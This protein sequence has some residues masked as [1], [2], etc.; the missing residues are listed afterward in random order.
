MSAY[1]LSIGGTPK[2]TV[3]EKLVESLGKV[4][5]RSLKNPSSVQKTCQN[6]GSIWGKVQ[7]P[8]CLD[9]GWLEHLPHPI[10]SSYRNQ[11]SETHRRSHQRRNQQQQLQTFTPHHPDWTAAAV[12]NLRS[13]EPT[14]TPR[15]STGLAAFCPLWNS[16]PRILSPPPWGQTSSWSQRKPETSSWM[17]M[18]VPW[19]DCLEEAHEMK[20]WALTSTSQTWKVA[21]CQP[22]LAAEGLWGSNSIGLECTEH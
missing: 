11:F 14:T 18:T 16:S 21:V 15:N 22:R 3:S 1:W 17:E 13:Q 9:R 2:P 5:N 6:I 7:S 19:E 10:L 4:L 12:K 20:N 8:H